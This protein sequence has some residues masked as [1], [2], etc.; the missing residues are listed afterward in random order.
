MLQFSVNSQ[1]VVVVPV[2]TPRLD[3]HLSGTFRTFE[4]QLLSLFYFSLSQLCT[5]KHTDNA[6]QVDLCDSFVFIKEPWAV[7]LFL[8]VE[9]CM[10]G[11]IEVKD[12]LPMKTGRCYFVEQYTHLHAIY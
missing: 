11:S 4:F 7:L 5:Y 9:I 6:T 2:K 10:L 3:F 8:Y 1:H 12:L